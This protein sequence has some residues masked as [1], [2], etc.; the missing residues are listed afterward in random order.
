MDMDMEGLEAA[1][2]RDLEVVIATLQPR[3]ISRICEDIFSNLP[4]TTASV[5]AYGGTSTA[6]QPAA[7]VPAHTDPSM[8]SQPTV[9]VPADTAPPNDNQPTASVL[10]HTDK[11][12]GTDGEGSQTV[13][14]VVTI[15]SSPQSVLAVGRQHMPE[16]RL[17]A[18]ARKFLRTTVRYGIQKPV[19]Y[20]SP[21]LVE[22]AV[23]VGRLTGRIVTSPAQALACAV[24]GLGLIVWKYKA[25]I[26]LSLFQTGF[27]FV[28][29]SILVPICEHAQNGAVDICYPMCMVAASL[30][31]PV[32]ACID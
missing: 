30:E 2:R 1:G 24:F 7:S 23:Q 25:A 6:S 14:P 28:D 12:I 20:L 4:T 26:A 13:L 17:R 27:D 15:P 18:I 22:L 10:A 16:P 5:Q 19:T 32:L 31:H 11:S 3:L 9:S 21:V 8:E 29:R